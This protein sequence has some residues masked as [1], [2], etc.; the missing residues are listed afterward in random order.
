MLSYH[1]LKLN[2]R[3]LRAF[4]SLD[5]EEFER[6]LIPFEKAWQDYINQHYIRQLGLRL[7]QW[8]GRSP[9]EPRIRNPSSDFLLVVD[10]RC[11]CWCLARSDT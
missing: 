7:L 2:P 6:L 3:V 5:P 1:D 9:G 4:T 10:V 8:L 11:R